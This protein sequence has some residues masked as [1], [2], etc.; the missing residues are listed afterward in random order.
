MS[1]HDLL[2]AFICVF[3]PVPPTWSETF[4]RLGP[5]SPPPS[6]TSSH[7][8]CAGRRVS[9]YSSKHCVNLIGG[10]YLTHCRPK[11]WRTVQCLGLS[12]LPPSPL[13]PYL[14]FVNISIYMCKSICTRHV[15]PK[16]C[17]QRQSLDAPRRIA[18]AAL[19][20]GIV[21]CPRGA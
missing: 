9:M 21:V 4:L 10:R 17:K 1:I 5:P 3:F 15:P 16:T 8:A 20:V 2:R 18:T 7:G 11:A 13:R 6:L 19:G 12:P 14:P